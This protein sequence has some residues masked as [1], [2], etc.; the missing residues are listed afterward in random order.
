MNELERYSVINTHMK[1]ELLLLQGTGCVWK[2]CR[3]CDYYNDISEDPFSVN[4][5]IIDKISGIHGVVDAINSGSIFELDEKTLSYLKEKLHE[6][7]IKTLW[8]ECHWLY[9]NRLD[10]IREFFSGINVKFRIGAETFDPKIRSAWNK[11]I[12]EN[13]TSEMIGEY[14]DGAC[15]LV[16][17]QGQTQESVIKDIEAAMKNFEYFNVNVFIENSTEIKKDNELVKW[18]INEIAPKL[19]KYENIEVLVNNTDLGVG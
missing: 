17:I 9:R 14:F 12:P 3:F 13:I 15:L 18:F 5:P 19:E 7:N 8:C 6:K 1:R 16:G 11:G 4:K 2:K 10:E